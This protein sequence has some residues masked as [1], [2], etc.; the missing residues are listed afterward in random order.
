MAKSKTADANRILDH[1]MG[2]DPELR[3]MIA[4]ATL[5]AHVAQLI[6]DAR[7]AAGLT[8]KQLADR[9]H[10]T[11]PVISQLEDAD[12]QGHSLSMLQRISTA[13]HQRLEIAFIPDKKAARR[14]RSHPSRISAKG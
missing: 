1:D 14:P 11:Q 10:S 2:H 6:Y 5:N 8:Q 3:R 9:I 13:L 7:T 4:E 12:Y